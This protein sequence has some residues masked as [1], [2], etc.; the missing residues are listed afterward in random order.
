MYCL[1]V[2]NIEIFVICHH[3]LLDG[4]KVSC[5]F[6]NL[7]I[8]YRYAFLLFL[9]CTI[10]SGV[11]IGFTISEATVS[12]DGGSTEVLISAIGAILSS[13]VT[14]SVSTVY[15]SAIGK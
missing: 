7:C 12:E 1:Y 9:V 8:L 5:G 4:C 10:Y 3:L 6:T 2:L 15:Q 13:S 14:T 11:I